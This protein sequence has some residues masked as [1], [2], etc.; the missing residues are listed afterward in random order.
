MIDFW[1]RSGT[2]GIIVAPFVVFFALSAMIT[3]ITFRSPARPFFA[4]C[5][6]IAGPFFVSVGVLFSLFAA[7]LANDVWRQLE[8]A[9]LAVALEADGIRTILRLAEAEGEIGKPL[10]AAALNYT[11]LVVTSEWPAMQI[12]KE[13][14]EALAALQ[15]LALALVSKEFAS[16]APAA[17]HQ[18]AVDAFVEIRHARTDRIAISSRRGQSIN[19]LGMVFLGVLTQVAVAVVHLEK[20]RPQALALTVF[21][22]AFAATVALIGL[23][24]RPF[25][26]VP[27][28]PTP[29]NAAAATAA[30]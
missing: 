4:S 15:G 30:R 11:N 5:I 7:F 24:E 12:G 3:W 8:R 22:F 27:I 21:T 6:G 25:A 17:F 2:I 23:N 20:L 10:E 16:N 9:Q 1:L 19:W 14:S 13:S 18:A 29:L 26:G 28:D